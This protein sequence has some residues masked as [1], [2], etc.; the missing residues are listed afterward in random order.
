MLK[1][2][3]VPKLA[4]IGLLILAKSRSSRELWIP[5]PGSQSM[6]DHSFAPFETT[7]HDVGDLHRVLELFVSS[8]DGPQAWRNRG[9]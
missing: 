7:G 3:F 1:L 5:V 4:S 9:L 6:T 2:A 8:N